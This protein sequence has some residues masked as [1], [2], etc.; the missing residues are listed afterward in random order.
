MVR[1]NFT[2]PCGRPWR[3]PSRP[4]GRRGV[5]GGRSSPATPGGGLVHLEGAPEVE[6]LDGANAV[7]DE[8]VEGRQQCRT[9][10]EVASSAARSTRHSPFVPSTTAGSP[11]SP[12]STGSSG[13]ALA[14]CWAMPSEASRRSG[15][16]QASLVDRR[17]DDIGRVHPL[18]QAPQQLQGPA[19]G[20]GLVRGAKRRLQA[21]MSALGAIAAVESIC[22]RVSPLHDREQVGRPRCVEQVR[23]HAMR[24]ACALVCARPG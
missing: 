4:A 22:S 19:G 5:P 20:G 12:T 17:D 9:S 16:G 8:P 7:V 18:G 6:Q 1:V 15:L 14:F 2:G 3:P 11:A 21:T 10:V 24:R 23:A 13:I